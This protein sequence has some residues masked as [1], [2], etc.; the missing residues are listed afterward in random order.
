MKITKSQLRKLIREQ[1]E[2]L[3]E[4]GSPEW[5]ND[6][7]EVGL[8]HK[9]HRVPKLPADPDWRAGYRDGGAGKQPADEENDTYM[10]GYAAGQR[11]M[12]R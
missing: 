9:S 10:N 11:G 4:K 8:D 1:L 6:S 7:W 2:Q 12:Y 3:S 5:G